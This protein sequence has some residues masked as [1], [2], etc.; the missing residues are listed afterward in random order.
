MQFP[1]SEMCSSMLLLNVFVY[2]KYD[3]AHRDNKR[4]ENS[5]S[6]R[7]QEVK[8]NRKSLNRQPQI[9]VAVAY[10]R[11]SFTRGSNTKT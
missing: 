2:S 1:S 7:L 10:R 4:S 6:G 9:V 8:S 11:C 3:S 5:S